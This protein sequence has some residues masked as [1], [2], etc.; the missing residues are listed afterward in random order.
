M[1]EGGREEGWRWVGG[2]WID[3][4]G[5]GCDQWEGLVMV[6]RHGD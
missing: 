3:S 4:Q 6:V 1:Q 5:E 2:G